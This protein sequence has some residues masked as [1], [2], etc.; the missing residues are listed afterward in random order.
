MGAESE[1]GPSRCITRSSAKSGVW[2]AVQT[3]IEPQFVLFFDCPEE[4]MEKRLLG[5]N[6][7]RT[8]D[9]IET[10]RKRFRVRAGTARLC[11]LPDCL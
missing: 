1:R 3:G 11:C 9:N 2:L 4:V 8:D 6:Q 5:R 7:G 10:I